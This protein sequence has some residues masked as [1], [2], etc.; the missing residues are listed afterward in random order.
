MRVDPRFQVEVTHVNRQPIGNAAAPPMPAPGP[1]LPGDHSRITRGH[2]TTLQ[3]SQTKLT[4]PLENKVPTDSLNFSESWSKARDKFQD[5]DL[6]NLSQAEAELGGFLAE[7]DARGLQNHPQYQQLSR[8]R[9]SLRRL[10]EREEV[11]RAPKESEGLLGEMSEAWNQLLGVV[12]GPGHHQQRLQR[13]LQDGTTMAATGRRDAAIKSF[14]RALV[15][16]PDHAEANARIGKLLLEAQRYPEAEAHLQRAVTY[17]PRDFDLHVSLGELYYHLG[18]NQ[19]SQQAF[20]QAMILNSRHSDPHAWL[21]ILAYEENRMPE[22]ARSLEHAVALDPANAVA[23]FYLAQLAYQL[24]DP[25]RANYQL[26]MVNRLEPLAD[27]QRFASDKPALPAGNPDPQ[28]DA[29]RWIPPNG[30]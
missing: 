29:H 13:Y 21:G 5:P 3:W 12:I 17:R 23:R 4:R 22:A 30:R 27:L 19:L 7:L 11:R 24:N 8:L 1:T 18:E 9:D 28:L 10:A 6:A 20:G 14:K 16:N 26:Q 15:L 25:L 2:R